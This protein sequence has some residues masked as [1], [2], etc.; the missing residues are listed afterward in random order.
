V[1]PNYSGPTSE[2]AEAISLGDPE[3]SHSCNL[4][5]LASTNSQARAFLFWSRSP[6]LER[7]PD[8]SVILRDARFYN[9]L[10]RDRFSV[11]LPDVA[12]RPLRQEPG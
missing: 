4:N 11:A 5:A 7:A 3:L 9:P 1:V 6:L 2:R 12:C 8:G 10:T